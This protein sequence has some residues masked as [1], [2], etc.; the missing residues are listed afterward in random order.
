MTSMIAK[1]FTQKILGE[2]ISNKFGTE[3][4]YFEHVPATRLNGTPSG[5]LKKRK[6]ALPP[7]ISDHDAKVLTKVKRRAYRLDLS[8]FNCCGIRFGWSS[9]IGLVPAIGD[10]LDALMALIVMRTCGQIEGGLPTSLK[11]KMMSN[12]ILDFVVGL[13]PFVG[14]VV[15]ALF[16]ANTR[17]AA[18]LEVYLREQG[19]KNLR[20]KGQPLPAVD[21]SDP[22]E[23]DRLQNETPPDRSKSRQHDVEMGDSRA[24]PKSSSR[25]ERR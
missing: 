12:I 8:L 1:F 7:G 18:L 24:Q 17:N 20:N 3:D 25:R 11:A 5:K 9:A 23:F 4:P 22:D 6:K 14:D 2:S 21:P 10:V 15:D 13:V 19:K 16:R